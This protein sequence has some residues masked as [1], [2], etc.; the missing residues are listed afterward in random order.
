MIQTSDDA[1]LAFRMA[2]IEEELARTLRAECPTGTMIEGSQAWH[3]WRIAED[4]ALRAS[5]L[6]GLAMQFGRD[7]AAQ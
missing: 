1:L 7:V 3:K 4:A 2:A 5:R 6:Q